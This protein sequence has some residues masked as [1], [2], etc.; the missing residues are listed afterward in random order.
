MTA[1]GKLNRR[2]RSL[3]D[4]AD[5]LETI[6]LVRSSRRGRKSRLKSCAGSI[7][8]AS[9]KLRPA[10]GFEPDWRPSSQDHKMAEC[11]SFFDARPARY[12]HVFVFPP[13]S[14]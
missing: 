11:R 14:R 10:A 6:R 8:A 12:P 4:L 13:D 7:P 3:V 1:A 2:D 5:K 9:I